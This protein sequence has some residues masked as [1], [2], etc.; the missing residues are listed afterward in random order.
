MA[1]RTANYSAFYVK[2]P[3]SESNLGAYATPDF[4]Y[5]NQL[6]A[7][8]ASDSSFP[9]VDAHE[10]TYN[11]QSN[12][13]VIACEDKPMCLGGVMGGL[14]S[15][16]TEDTKNIMLEAAV[17][18]PM[19]IRKTAARLNLHSES[20]NRYE[21]GVDINRT[22]QALD[23]ACYLF[24]TLADAKICGE[25]VSVGT[26]SI[27]DKEIELTKTMVDSRLGT[28]IPTCEIKQILESLNFKVTETSKDTLM[29]YVPN[30][31][32]DITIKEETR[33]EH[34][35]VIE[36]SRGFRIYKDKIFNSYK[37]ID[38]LNDDINL[39]INR[40]FINDELYFDAISLFK[41]EMN[42]Q[43][44]I[45]KYGDELFTDGYLFHETGL[46]KEE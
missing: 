14:N 7:W 33:N 13:I 46:L 12:D 42:Y 40:E 9:F 20:S 25:P 37:V 23:Y 41:K 27:K 16:I 24:K 22:R 34:Y 18:D 19:T 21:R 30:R 1:N 43:D 35:K 29:V 28:D 5:Y 3:F 31:R 36:D 10:K 32:P 39:I 11:V 45:N 38:K 17:F 2:E 26:T 44:F 6:C 8:K 4:M 15:E